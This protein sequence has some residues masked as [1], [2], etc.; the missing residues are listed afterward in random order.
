MTGYVSAMSNCF[1]CGKLFSYNPVTVPS[2]TPP[3]RSSREPICRDCVKR[4]NPIRRQKGLPEIVPL[5]GA[6]EAAEEGEM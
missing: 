6:Y 5:P 4:V 3:G 1:G 2:I